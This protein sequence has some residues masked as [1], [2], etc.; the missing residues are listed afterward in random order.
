[1]DHG[2]SLRPGEGPGACDLCTVC[3]HTP[4]CADA[5]SNPCTLAHLHTH[6]GTPAH[7]W[8]HL[9][10]HLSTP[11][12]LHTPVPKPMHTQTCAHTC[13][14]TYTHT[15]AHP[16]VHIP[17][18]THTNLSY[19]HA[20]AHTPAHSCMGP[21]AFIVSWGMVICPVCVSALVWLAIMACPLEAWGLPP[22]PAAAL[23]GR[24]FQ[25]CPGAGG[26]PP[27]EGPP[28]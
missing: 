17:A 4:F 18:H 12:H 7:T 19:T 13:T 1:M 26:R 16:P 25:H 6:L 8:A 10:T 9:H 22:P 3:T 21:T 11:A 28:E 23:C 2:V 5:H 20:P 15:L 24:G 14:L 27:T